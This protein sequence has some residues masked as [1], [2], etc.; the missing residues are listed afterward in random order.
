MVAML[1]YLAHCHR[2]KKVKF[3]SLVVG[4]IQIVFLP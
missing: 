1:Y 2:R 4:Y 3:W